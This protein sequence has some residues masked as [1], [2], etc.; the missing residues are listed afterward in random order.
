[1]YASVEARVPFLDHELIEFSYKK[2]P[3][4]LKL[5][6]NSVEA[7][8][9]A[10][11]KHSAEYSEVLDTPKYLLKRYA[12]ELLPED[13]VNRKKVGFPVPLNN[14]FPNL[15]RMAYEK[16]DKTSWIKK[17]ALKELCEDCKAD[18]KAGQILWMFLNIE[19]F[20]KLY[21]DKEWRY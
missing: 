21:F 20:R 10:M 4:D 16:L 12:L 9:I 6:W 15:E 5:K 13:V 18:E 7:K 3:Y 17:E 11:E 2:I 8:N 1:M 19:M 14:W